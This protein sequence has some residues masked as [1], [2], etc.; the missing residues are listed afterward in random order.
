MRGTLQKLSTTAA[1]FA[2]N[3]TRNSII[4]RCGAVLISGPEKHSGKYLSTLYVGAGRNFEFLINRL[5]V[6]ADIVEKDQTINPIAGLVLCRQAET[7]VDLIIIDLDLP[8]SLLYSSRAYLRVPQWVKQQLVLPP[9]KRTFIDSL[10]RKL[11]REISRCIRKYHYTY[12]LV[13]TKEQFKYFYHR[14][15]APFIRSRFSNESVVVSEAFFLSQCRLG[16]ILRLLRD[17][18]PVAGAVLQLE[19]A[20]LSSVWV[21]FATTNVAKSGTGWSDVLDYFTIDY[22]FSKGYRTIDFGPSRPLLDDGVFRYK[23]KWGTS[24]HTSKLPTGDILFHSVKLNTPVRSVME[25]N[26]WITRDGGKLA[27]HLMVDGQ[28]IG[29]REFQKIMRNCGAG[30]DVIKVKSFRSFDPAINQAAEGVE[31][32][33]LIDLSKSPHLIRDLTAL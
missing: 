16:L 29:E 25:N 13:D 14:F 4:P 24:V 33:Q 19:K 17:G 3:L 11:R 23:R 20:Q 21:G 9:S 27:G 6:G 12:D 8:Y 5:F 7:D 1:S 32:I 26:F 10:P 15:Y 18:Q 28:A 31:G 22:A 2:F 30:I